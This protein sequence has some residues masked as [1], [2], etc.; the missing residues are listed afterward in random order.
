MEYNNEVNNYL[1]APLLCNSNMNSNIH[2][3]LNLFYLIS[4][5]AF[6]DKSC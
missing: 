1:Q 3:M 4:F 5:D 6:Q 2:Q